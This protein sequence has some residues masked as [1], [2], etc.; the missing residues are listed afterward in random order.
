MKINY[1]LLEKFCDLERY[2][3][4]VRTPNLYGDK[5]FAT[6]GHIGILVDGKFTE[7]TCD[8]D[9][10]KVDFESKGEYV[11]LPKIE[12]EKKCDVCEGSKYTYSKKCRNCNNTGTV[13]LEDDA[14]NEYECECK[15]CYGEAGSKKPS[16]E[17]SGDLCSNCRGTGESI[18]EY[19]QF[20]EQKTDDA[21][22]GISAVNL[23][24]MSNL[25]NV[26]IGTKLTTSKNYAF[27]F[28]GGVGIV[29]PFQK[30]K[31]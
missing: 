7:N 23:S 15:E 26:K 4:T 16:N 2:R 11:E 30:F 14:L 9:I 8:F 3:D 18:Y 5:T 17:A 24:L 25:P 21:I 29:M 12:T 28:D 6:N 10:E 13:H 1:E 20:G 31:H 22:W 27:R 19:V